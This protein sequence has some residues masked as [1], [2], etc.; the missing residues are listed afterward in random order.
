MGF[1]DIGISL[2]NCSVVSITSDEILLR[3]LGRNICR[4]WL[5]FQRAN[6]GKAENGY[7]Y[8]F[9]TLPYPIIRK[10]Y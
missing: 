1:E 3:N 2:V 7:F 8:N 5:T 6:K 9:F 4:G 10:S